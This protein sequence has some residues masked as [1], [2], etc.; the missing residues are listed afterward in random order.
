MSE[1]NSGSTVVDQ[2]ED[3]TTGRRGFLGLAGALA[4]IGVSIPFARNIPQGLIPAAHAQTDDLA[5]LLAE[6]RKHPGLS[7]IGDRPFVAETPEHLLDDET[8]PFDKF[9]V[10]HNGIPPDIPAN[11]DSWQ[12]SVEGLVNTPLTL[13][14]ADLKARFEEVSLHM[15]LE[16]G[17]N[18]RSFF[19]PPARG[20][21][22]TNGGAS[23]GQWTGV[24][25]RDVLNAAGV[26]SSAI[27]TAHYGADL[28]LSGDPDRQVISR[29]VRLEKAMEEHCLIAW[30]MNGGP[31]PAI[32]GGPLR[33]IIPG[34]PGSASHKWVTRIELRDVEHDGPGMTG[35][36]YRVPA[37][38][39]IPGSGPEGVTFD[40]L[41]SMPVRSVIS[42]PANGTRLAA[43]SRSLAL[44]G[45]AWG[46]DTAVEAV[47]VSIDFGA[48]WHDVN[49]AQPRNRY[50]WRRWT[51]NLDLPSDGYYEVWVRATDANGVAQPHIAGNWNPQGYGG[52]PMH[53]VAVLVA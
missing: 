13:S 45:A 46:G 30:G 27:Y 42:S 52:N 49:L 15:V 20:N 36:S 7:V 22:W 10:R 16:C 47:H 31:L 6:A 41:E 35:T 37:T 33:L 23:C 21:Q 3:A 48:T 8:T 5:A 4:A 19:D 51:A 53:R 17:G 14:L 40:I 50:D 12:I 38:P 26:Q 43:G 2:V 18:G 28:H 9:F 39:M 44:R 29:G 24:R 1:E 11:P 25:L 34:W 32:H